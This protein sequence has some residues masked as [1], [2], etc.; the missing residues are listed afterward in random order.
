MKKIVL[1][2]SILLSITLTANEVK[3]YKPSFSCSNVKKESIEYKICSDKELSQLDTILSR[4]YQSFR[5]VTNEIKQEQKAWL[6][7]RKKCKTKECIKE[8]YLSRAEQLLISLK[9]QK[10]FPK[11]ILDVMESVEKNKLLYVKAVNLIITPYTK[12]EKAFKNDLFHF[13]NFTFIKPIKSNLAYD[14]EELKKYLGECYKYDAYKWFYVE[15]DFKR[16]NGKIVGKYQYIHE[17]NPA[18]RRINSISIYNPIEIGKR[19]YYLLQFYNN[20]FLL[21]DKNYCNTFGKK[22]NFDFLKA[23]N[24]DIIR[25]N[26]EKSG[27]FYLVKYKNQLAVLNVFSDNG[28][29]Y[30]D[31]EL[32]ALLGNDG[33]THKELFVY[34]LLNQAHYKAKDNSIY[35]LY[36]EQTKKAKKLKNRQRNK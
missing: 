22:Y 33:K 18:D 8:S 14:S 10:T 29:Q 7:Q 2:I 30:A 24:A 9:G 35:E 5:L 12:E 34:K 25:A 17:D 11:H 36:L 21:I 1:I 32:Y 15:K 6:K 20:V 16:V 23:L 13:R 19:N 27:K 26:I 31:F 28:K 4:T 3:F